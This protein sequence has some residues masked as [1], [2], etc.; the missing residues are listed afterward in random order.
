MCK[1]WLCYLGFVICDV[2]YVLCYV[3]Y[4]LFK[5]KVPTF[6]L[7]TSWLQKHLETCFCTFFN[8]PASAKSNENISLLK[9]W[10]WGNKKKVRIK[11]NETSTIHHFKNMVF[12][13]HLSMTFP[14]LILEWN[15]V[16]FGFCR[17]LP[18]EN[19]TETP[20]KMF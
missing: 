17:G 6:V 8:S 16:N 12:S 18:N 1:M 19:H 5:R 3:W 4:R 13:L 14:I 2:W 7:L 20:W 10:I 15:N 9:D 11:V